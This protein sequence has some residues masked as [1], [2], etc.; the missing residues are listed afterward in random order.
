MAKDETYYQRLKQEN[1]DLKAMISWAD[2]SF[3]LDSDVDIRTI[4]GYLKTKPEASK[5][6]YKKYP[7]ARE[8]LKEI[9]DRDNP[10]FLPDVLESL[11]EVIRIDAYKEDA[12]QVK[13]ELFRLMGER[14]KLQEEIDKQEKEYDEISERV[15]SLQRRS[16]EL[17]RQIG[18]ITDPEILS[19]IKSLCKVVSAFSQSVLKSGGMDELT[20]KIRKLTS[21]QVQTLNLLGEKA[22]NTLKTISDEDALSELKLS[23]QRQRYKDQIDQE[24]EI[25]LNEMNAFMSHNPKKLLSKILNNVDVSMRKISGAPDDGASGFYLNN[26]TAGMVKGNLEESM[27]YINHLLDQMENKARHEK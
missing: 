6:I 25:A 9:C 1:Q 2:E 21:D 8:S 15:E 17:D 18:N 12:E 27:K 7:K 16:E 23:E 10:L 11:S 5:F 4:Y 20:L 19:Q 26:L 22:N 3:L 24:K 14:S 13:K